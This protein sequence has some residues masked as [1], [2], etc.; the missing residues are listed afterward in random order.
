[1]NSKPPDP[2]GGPG[3][4]RRNVNNIPQ[5]G[6]FRDDGEIIPTWAGIAAGAAKKYQEKKGGKLTQTVCV[7]L[8]RDSNQVSYNVDEIELEHL[9]FDCIGLKKQEDLMWMDMSYFRTLIFG[10]AHDVDTKGLALGISHSI[11]EGLKSKAVKPPASEV[12]LKIF[13]TAYGTDTEAITEALSNFGTVLGEYENQVF[14]AYRKDGKPSRL[15]GVQKGDL[16]VRFK[17]ERA[18]PTYILV[19]NKKIKVHFDGQTNCCPR[20]YKFPIKMGIEGLEA[21]Y[22][23][24]DPK[25]CAKQDPKGADYKY[26]FE[27]EW[28]KLVEAKTIKG[29]VED[30]LIGGSGFNADDVVEI[31]NLPDGVEV[32]E[33]KEWIESTGLKLGEI[34]EEN[35][36]FDDSFPNKIMISGLDAEIAEK[37]HENCWGRTMREGK[38]GG[39]VFVDLVRNTKK[40]V[41]EEKGKNVEEQREEE[42]SPIDLDEVDP[43]ELITEDEEEAGETEP[44][45]ELFK[46]EKEVENIVNEA[47]QRRNLKLEE[48]RKQLKSPEGGMI[49]DELKVILGDRKLTA[50]AVD[51]IC[52]E[53]GIEPD[54][55]QRMRL[56][57]LV[58]RKERDEIMERRTENKL[59]RGREITTS[60]GK[61]SPTDK[62]SKTDDGMETPQRP[63]NKVMHGLLAKSQ[64]KSRSPSRENIK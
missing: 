4:R 63:L 23:K 31:T 2:G 35:F 62:K 33:V 13:W 59:K 7:Q 54:A 37:I 49:R 44:L 17:P 53:K 24:G 3:W 10:I 9:I 60:T 20:C 18:V 6:V 5:P 28:K 41:E 42:T 30:S 12:K 15:A 36:R 48:L 11:R 25:E 16:V 29:S 21:C 61:Q 56:H 32:E 38:G 39:K 8:T 46:G 40:A 43:E 57:N 51:E 58:R 14:S 47:M 64:L 34:T 50:S 45:D 1:M 55:A 52:N 19:K 22:G 27:A 26:E